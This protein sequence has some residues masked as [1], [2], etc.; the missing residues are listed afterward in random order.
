M[1]NTKSTNTA[2]VPKIPFATLPDF[3]GLLPPSC[4]ISPPVRLHKPYD[5]TRNTVQNLSE[6]SA[7]DEFV[8]TL[9]KR[10]VLGTNARQSPPE[11]NGGIAEIAGSAAR[12]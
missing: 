10:N 2:A 5:V 7:G 12:G 11:K 6:R 8:H 3:T 4:K 1:E 9:H